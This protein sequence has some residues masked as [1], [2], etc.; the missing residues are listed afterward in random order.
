MLDYFKMNV[1]IEDT[2]YI[3]FNEDLMRVSL[4]I[5]DGNFT[6][7]MR[8]YVTKDIEHFTLGE[9][10]FS[11][12]N[13]SITNI[14]RIQKIVISNPRW[15]EH[16]E[17]DDTEAF[18][19]ELDCV[20]LYLLFYSFNRE[21]LGNQYTNRLDRLV[22]EFDFALNFCCNDNFVP[23]FNHLSSM[24]RYYLYSKIYIDN[25]NTIDRHYQQHRYLF[26]EASQTDLLNML[27]NMGKKTDKFGLIQDEFEPVTELPEIPSKFLSMFHNTR[28]TPIFRYEYSAI[29]RYLM[30][31][32][33][34]LIKLNIRIKKCSNCGKYFILKGDYATDYCDR[35]IDGQK[36]TC[37]KFA[38]IQARKKKVKSNPVIRE[39]EKAY[40]R[41]YAR[42]TNKKLSN[43]D[44]RLWTEEASKKREEA[45]ARYAAS[46]SE[47]IIK[48]F[49][50]YLGNR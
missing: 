50:E 39:Y 5:E 29:E 37:K 6:G 19:A 45:A 23:Q 14:N 48:E 8:T 35:I 11:F 30:E 7:D 32:L 49:K 43:E 12:L 33:F 38:A 22:K 3:M 36:Y 18:L 21:H 44:F 41:Y 28:V 46:P 24:E 2:A 20:Y 16:H 47:D 31:E 9:N 13:L 1:L 26:M 40:K 17:Q 42:V 25:I 27:P 10:L 34:L 4:C 15:D